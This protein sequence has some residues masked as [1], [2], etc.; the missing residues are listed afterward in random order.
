VLNAAAGNAAVNLLWRSCSSALALA[1]VPRRR[2]FGIATTIIVIGGYVLFMITVD[3]P[4]YV[5]RWH[6]QMASIRWTHP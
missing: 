1:L 2:A 4:M 5:A 6:A 3:A